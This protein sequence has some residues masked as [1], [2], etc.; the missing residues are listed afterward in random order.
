MVFRKR[1]Y[2]KK[3]KDNPFFDKLNSYFKSKVKVPRIRVGKNQ[4][5]ETQIVVR[6]KTQKMILGLQEL[7]FLLGRLMV[8]LVQFLI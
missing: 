7:L 4:E 8:M 1:Q 2:L 3:K 5:I 6:S